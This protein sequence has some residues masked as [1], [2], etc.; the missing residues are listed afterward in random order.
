MARY[1]VAVIALL[2]GL[3]EARAQM[4]ARSVE[5][6]PDYANALAALAVLEGP[7]F[8][9]GDGYSSTLAYEWV[10]PGVLLRARNELRNDAGDVVGEYEGHYAWDPD[11][12]TIVFWTVGRDGDLHRGTA[13]WRDGQ[14]WH[15]GR[16]SGGR[17]TGYR[18]VLDVEG[19]QLHY[20][21]VYEPSASEDDVL[22]SVPLIYR[23]PD[24]D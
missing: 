24:S 8:A 14:L 11:Q 21:A 16:V 9:N 7:W 23:R 1:V 19:E 6:P 5:Q 10:L 18:S 20:L 4:P 22:G 12:A 17:V 13:A 2:A 15:E 3:A